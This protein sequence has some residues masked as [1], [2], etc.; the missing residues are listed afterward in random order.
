MNT[1]GATYLGTKAFRETGALLERYKKGISPEMAQKGY[2]PNLPILERQFPV[3]M[4]NF[5][6]TVWRG[7]YR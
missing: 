6:S 3:L 2:H 4:E 5:S 7:V 1:S